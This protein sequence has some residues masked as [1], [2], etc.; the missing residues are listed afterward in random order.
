MERAYLEAAALL[1]AGIKPN[2]VRIQLEQKLGYGSQARFWQLWDFAIEVGAPLVETLQQQ[3]EIEKIQ[4]LAQATLAKL[5]AAPKSTFR[6]VAVLPVFALIASQLGGLNPLAVFRT[7]VVPWLSVSLGALLMAVAYLVSKRLLAAATPKQLEVS[8]TMRRF[9]VAATAGHST[10]RCFDLA[11]SDLGPDSSESDEA[12]HLR[13]LLEP[14]DGFGA[15]PV[16]LVR[17]ELNLA[18]EREQNRQEIALE[19]ASVRLIAPA[20]LLSMPAF[21]LIALVPTAMSL[22][23]SLAG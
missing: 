8:Q 15:A 5:Y 13:K 6:L 19:R 10:S 3:A 2:Q 4:R 20:A 22:G 16:A 11:S 14:I 23:A 7:S 17:S 18:F 9:L 21:A 1:Q 12:Q